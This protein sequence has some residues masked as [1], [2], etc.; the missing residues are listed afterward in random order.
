MSQIYELVIGY[1]DEPYGRIFSQYKFWWLPHVD[2]NILL[3][4]QIKKETVNI[5]TI[6]NPINL[7]IFRFYN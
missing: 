6:H 1:N 4:D 5:T 2:M 7:H 3:K